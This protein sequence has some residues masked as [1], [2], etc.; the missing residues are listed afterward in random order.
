V[1]EPPLP[2]Q[3]LRRPWHGAPDRAEDPA[4]AAIRLQRAEV[5]ALL[6]WR[7]TDPASPDQARA[8]R[9]LAALREMR[10]ALMPPELAA[11]LPPLPPAPVGALSRWQKLRRRL[12]FGRKRG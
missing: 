8:W 11:Q 4:V 5:E 1:A 2:D 7:R 9:R 3:A 6:A 10:V 12:G